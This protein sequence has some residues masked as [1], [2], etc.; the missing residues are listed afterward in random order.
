MGRIR[1]FKV[2][3]TKWVIYVTY[4]PPR[5]KGLQEPEVIDDCHETLLDTTGCPWH[6]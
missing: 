6:T 4:L 5:A 3:G 1:D 2:F